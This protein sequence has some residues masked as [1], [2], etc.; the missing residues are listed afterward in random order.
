MSNARKVTYP[1]LTWE[2]LQFINRVSA[3]A[4]DKAFRGDVNG[5]KGRNTV[6]KQYTYNHFKS[7]LRALFTTPDS[8]TTHEIGEI[9]WYMKNTDRLKLLAQR[10]SL[11]K[12]CST[13]DNILRN[14]THLEDALIFACAH[15]KLLFDPDSEVC[16]KNIDMI[17]HALP[18]NVRDTFSRFAKSAMAKETEK[19]QRK[20]S[21]KLDTKE[22]EQ[23]QSTEPL[24]LE[25]SAGTYLAAVG[26]L[27]YLFKADPVY[28]A[29]AM[30]SAAG[31]LSYGLYGMYQEG[32]LN[33]W[34]SMWASRHC[35]NNE[36]QRSDRRL[37]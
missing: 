19:Y 3:Y 17:V 16:A 12:N 23:V 26:V 6:L 32:K 7:G 28:T 10:P 18:I 29:A 21:M 9:L 27:A 25:F 30:L 34:C 35:E 5:S 8:L 1:P 11:I 37:G 14:Y 24:N 4:V 22:P 15:T 20:H 33:R 36:V 31:C 2:D 13:L